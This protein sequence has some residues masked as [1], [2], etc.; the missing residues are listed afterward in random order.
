[1]KKDNSLFNLKEWYDDKTTSAVDLTDE[2]FH[3]LL[4][5]VNFELKSQELENGI[6]IYFLKDLLGANLGNIEQDIFYYEYDRDSEYSVYN[7]QE[8]W[9]KIKEAIFDRLEIYFYDYFDRDKLYE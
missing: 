5:F 6:I 8:D 2:Q 9:S 7:Q 4:E 1:M 3:E